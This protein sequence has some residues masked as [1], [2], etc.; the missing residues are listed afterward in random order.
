MN[1][2][3]NPDDFPTLIAK[4]KE[5]NLGHI[6]SLTA[7]QIQQIQAPTLLLVGDSDIIRLEHAVEMFKHLGGGVNGDV[8]GLP[9]SQLAILPGTSHTMM[10]E[11][12]DLL[13]LAITAFLDAPLAEAQ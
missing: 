9:R 4:V 5:M 7:E 8:D 3:P 1:S 2:A 13:S 10:V 6:P 12:G 11:R